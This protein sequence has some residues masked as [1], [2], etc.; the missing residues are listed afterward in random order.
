MTI[1]PVIDAQTETATRADVLVADGDFHPAA[2]AVV[3]LRIAAPDGQVQ[4][5]SASLAD[6]HHRA[7]LGTRA[8]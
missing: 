7:L 2:G 4:T 3:T 8:D 6:E 1:V 5:A